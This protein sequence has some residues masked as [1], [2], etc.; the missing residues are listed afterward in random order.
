MI[1]NKANKERLMLSWK[2]AVCHVIKLRFNKIQETEGLL[3]NLGLETLLREIP[4]LG[5]NLF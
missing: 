3:S 5:D 2:C 4:P 1:V